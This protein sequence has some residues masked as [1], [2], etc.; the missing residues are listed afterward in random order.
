MKTLRLWMVLLVPLLAFTLDARAGLKEYVAKADPTFTYELTETRQ[1]D[2]NSIDIIHLT[3]QT[4]EGLVWKHWLAIVRPQEV[5]HPEYALLVIGGGGISEK[6]PKF[7]DDEAKIARMVANATKSVVAVLFQVPNE[8]LFGGKNEDEIIAYTYDKYLK[9]EGEEW[10]LLMPMVKSAVRAMDAVQALAKSKYNQDIQNFVLTG[11]S[12]RGWTT[13]LTAASGDPR[14]KGIVPVV[15]DMLDMPVQMQRQIAC[16][17]A[18]SEQIK[19][20]TDLKFQ[21]RLDSPEG[22]KLI[23]I[24]DPFAYRDALTL[25]KLVLLGTNDPYWTV[26]AASVYFPELKGEKHLYYQANTGHDANPQGVATLTQFYNCMVT[27]E[28]FPK[29]EWKKTGKG[30]LDV[31][32][33]PA[34]GKALL[35]QATS[36]NRDFREA[37]WKSQPLE[38]K[39]K[40]SVRANAPK[41]GWLAYYVEIRYPGQ[42]GFP[43]GSCTEMTVLPETMPHGG[44]EAVKEKKTRKKAGEKPAKSPRP[45]RKANR[46]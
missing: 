28:A 11:G 3:S 15:I 26:D 29:V 31:S 2:T 22:K 23:S 7:D 45:P 5:L 6:P 18:Y 24:V 13:W 20:Y 39:G 34:D 44:K 27:G 32:W 38:G 30:K 9:G 4:W 1:A 46:R 43:F 41:E 12:K 33:Q 10:P 21:E 35:W 40:V 14:V 42:F 37:E 8:P 19:D 16:Y 25:P 36:K 17:G